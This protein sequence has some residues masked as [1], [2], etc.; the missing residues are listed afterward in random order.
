MNV[1]S[2]LNLLQILSIE[3]MDCNDAAVVDNHC[4][5]V[6]C[7]KNKFSVSK[8]GFCS[9]SVVKQHTE[10]GLKL[11]IIEPDWFEQRSKYLKSLFHNGKQENTMHNR[12][13]IAK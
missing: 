8:S 4:I 10:N 11:N 12:A 2:N 9:F 1:Q 5:H 3:S 13:T 6:L 7:Y